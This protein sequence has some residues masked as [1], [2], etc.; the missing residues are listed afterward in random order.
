VNLAQARRFALSLPETTEEPHF[1]IASY[2]VRAKIFATVPESGTLRVFVDLP[3]VHAAVADDPVAFAELTW[4]ATVRGVSITLS[5]AAP[6]QV[7]ELL[8]LAWARRAPQRV[9]AGFDL[10]GHLQGFP[11]SAGR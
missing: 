1:D 5:K 4:G 2:R 3:E 7:Y 10:A 9:R 8:A 11:R 6:A